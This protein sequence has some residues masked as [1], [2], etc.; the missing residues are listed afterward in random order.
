M[1]IAAILQL[2]LL[3]GYKT[4]AG[5]AL[6]ALTA[7]WNAYGGQITTALSQFALSLIAAGLRNALSKLGQAT[8]GRPV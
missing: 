2:L 3:N 1:N 6:M 8:V 5:A 7:L 4:Y